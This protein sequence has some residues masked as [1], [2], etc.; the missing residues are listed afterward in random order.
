MIARFR[1]LPVKGLFLLAALAAWPIVAWAAELELHTRARA[2]VPQ[3]PDHWTTVEQLARWAPEKTAIII[4][5]MWDRHWC[6]GATARVGEMAPRM[7]AVLT[8]ARRRGVHIIHAPS[9]T[10]KFYAE[11]PQRKRAQQAPAAAAPPDVAKWKS[12]NQAKEGPLPIDDSDGGCN[13]VPPC[14]QGGPWRQQIA[15]LEIAP[16]DYVSDS[17]PEIYNVLQQLGVENVIVMGVHTNMCVLGRPFS[18]RA[19]VG[20]GKQVVLMRDLTDT[21]YNSRQRPWVNHCVGTDL[22]VE[23]IEKFWCPSITSADF[24]GGEPFRFREDRRPRVVYVL[25]ENE[26]QTATTL[27][28]FVQRT[29]AWRGLRADYVTASTRLDD[30]DFQNV[31]ALKDADLVF[32]SVRRRGMPARM[33]ALLRE[34]LEAGRPLVGIRTASHAFAPGGDELNRHPGFAEWP[35]LD[36]EVL[37]GNYHGH[38]G[39]GPAATVRPAPGREQDPRLTGVDTGF[40]SLSSLYRNG[41]LPEG[42]EPLL[43]AAIPDNPPEPVAWTHRYGPR[44]ARVFYTSLGGPRDFENAA[45]QRLLLNGLLWALDQPIPPAAARIE[46]P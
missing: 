12:L 31:E 4:C 37:G 14:P 43:V 11:Y 23:H 22:V 6:Q 10:M 38:Y 34:H 26:Y 42:T 9:D 36:R 41:P 46:H 25:A 20:L 32:L 16:E 40:Q 33:A 15:V 13:D 45:F 44:G 18:I 28:A 30:F 39:A 1:R 27:P 19:M 29:L 3:Q 2:A 7:N 5:D 35:S 24:L 8:E 21:M 17:G